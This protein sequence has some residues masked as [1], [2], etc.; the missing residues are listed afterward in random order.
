MRS[1]RPRL[2]VASHTDLF[3]SLAKKERTV[4]HFVLAVLQ[5]ILGFDNAVL[6]FAL[7]FLAHGLRFFQTIFKTASVIKFEIEFAFE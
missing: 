7:K 2:L 4:S 3:Q 6:L 1:Q 5:I